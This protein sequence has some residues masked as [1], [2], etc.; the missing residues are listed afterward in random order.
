[1]YTHYFSS[2]YFCCCLPLTLFSP[3]FYC[4]PLT[5]PVPNSPI[6]FIPLSYSLYSAISPLS[7]FSFPTKR[8]E[9]FSIIFPVCFKSRCTFRLHDYLFMLIYCTLVLVLPLRACTC[10][11][12]GPPFLIS[13][14]NLSVQMYVHIIFFSKVIA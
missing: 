4:L 7:N 2:L 10:I 3:Y 13:I 12:S 9:L 6:S 11:Y 14:F 5:N 8:S 1:M